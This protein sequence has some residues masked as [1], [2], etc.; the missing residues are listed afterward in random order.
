[1]AIFVAMTK[2]LPVPFR[3]RAR[4]GLL[5]GQSCRYVR[6]K[7]G[8]RG[9]EDCV[10]DPENHTACSALQE[11]DSTAADLEAGINLHKQ[12]STTLSDGNIS[13]YDRFSLKYR[14]LKSTRRIQ[15]EDE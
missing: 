7:W 3:C 9:G 1:M 4:I 11:K 15:K 2:L 8:G 10:S 6:K 13:N 14:L 12:V 5:R